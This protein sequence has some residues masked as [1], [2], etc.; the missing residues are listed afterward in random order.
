[1]L[2]YLFKMIK[3]LGLSKTLVMVKA[4]IFPQKVRKFD[5]YEG[6]LRNKK[7]LEIGGPSPIFQCGNIIPVYPLVGALDCCTFSS[8]T[9]WEGQLQAGQNYEYSK[10]K[11]KGQ[12]FITEASRLTGIAD[13]SYDFILASHVLEH[14][15]NPLKTIAEWLRV[16]R[17]GGA[18]V[19]IVPDKKTTFDHKRPLTTF[20]HLLEDYKKDVGE[21]DMTH[22][23]EILASHDLELDPPAGNLKSFKKR[24]GEN[25]KNRCL[26]HHVFSEYVMKQILN[27]FHMDVKDTVTVPPFN[28]IALATK[29]LT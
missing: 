26:H 7:G 12:Q 16:L 1:M 5:L 21:N 3:Q 14:T 15:A 11:P 9:V 17:P 23:E 10:S 20:E 6:L 18:L 22:L 29:E 4:K 27:H 8:E 25:F 19:I 28:I 24:C 13:G 2:N